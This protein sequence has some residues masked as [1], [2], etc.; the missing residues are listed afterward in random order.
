MLP[1]VVGSQTTPRKISEHEEAGSRAQETLT[2]QIRCKA[3][4]S[5]H[6]WTLPQKILQQFLLSGLG[7]RDHHPGARNVSAP[8]TGA[9]AQAVSNMPVHSAHA[10]LSSFTLTLFGGERRVRTSYLLPRLGWEESICSSWPQWPKPCKNEKPMGSG[11]ETH[12]S[13]RDEGY[14]PPKKK[15]SCF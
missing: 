6:W 9:H 14:P 8:G 2:E 3:W 5:Q 7:L 12:T 13:L 11:A 15:T 10:E 4:E 1:K